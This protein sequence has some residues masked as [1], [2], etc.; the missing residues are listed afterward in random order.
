MKITS[1]LLASL[2]RP[3]HYEPGEPLWTHPHIAAE[4]L[5]AHLDPTTDAASYAPQTIDRICAHLTDAMAPEARQ[6]RY[7]LGLRAGPVL[8]QAG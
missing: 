5:K 4:M 2:R 7:R 1:Q 6:P 8:P 3:S